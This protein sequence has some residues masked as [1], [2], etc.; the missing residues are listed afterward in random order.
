MVVTLRSGREIEGKKER[1]KKTD[2]KKEE[3]GGELKQYSSE[4][5]ERDRTRKMQ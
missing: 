1:K 2:E 3:I 4:V 5:A